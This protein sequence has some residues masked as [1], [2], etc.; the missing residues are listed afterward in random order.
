MWLKLL[1]YA[2]IAL[3]LLGVDHR[4]YLSGKEDAEQVCKDIT[5]PAALA[6]VK[7]NYDNL[8]AVSKEENNAVL[9]DAKRLRATYD[10]L[11]DTKPIANCVPITPR[12]GGDTG[13]DGTPTS[14]GRVGVSTEWLD[15]TF[16]GAANDIARGESCQRQLKNIY[17]L[18]GVTP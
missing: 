11:R 13:P 7:T 6:V 4:A 14:S 12:S 16:F 17:L 9:R 1:P 15:A 3:V 18:N 8:I 2:V 5:V 10:R